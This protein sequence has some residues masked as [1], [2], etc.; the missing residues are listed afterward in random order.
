MRIKS[1]KTFLYLVHHHC[2]FRGHK[3]LGIPRSTM[4]AH[5][6]ELEAATGLKLI[7]RRK[8]NSSLTKEGRYFAPYAERMVTYFE[9]GVIKAKD[10]GR[11]RA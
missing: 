3:I 4:W 8:Q 2:D 1:L 11:K 10:A 7:E 6:N 9:E 5:I